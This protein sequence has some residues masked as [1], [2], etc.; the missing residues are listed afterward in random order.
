MG[1]VGPIPPMGVPPTKLP[2]G[3]SANPVEFKNNPLG[4]GYVTKISLTP[5]LKFTILLLL[6]LEI[7]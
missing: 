4:P 7:I 2:A 6:L 3:N 5:A 1:P